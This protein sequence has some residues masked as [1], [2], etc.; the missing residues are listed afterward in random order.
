M[1]TAAIDLGRRVRGHP[2]AAMPDERQGTPAHVSGAAAQSQSPVA[3]LGFN[4]ARQDDLGALVRFHF[5]ELGYR[6][7]HEGPGEWVFERGKKSAAFLESNVRFY[8]TMLT[9]R[10]IA[11]GD[12]GQ[13][14]SCTWVVA[15]MGLAH[16]GRRDV[17][18]LESE[19]REL[20][21]LLTPSTTCGAVS[22][23]RST[24]T[25]IQADEESGA[26]TASASGRSLTDPDLDRIQMELKA[27]AVGLMIVALLHTLFWGAVG[28][29]IAYDEFLHPGQV[30]WKPELLGAIGGTVAFLLAAGTLVYGAIHLRRMTGY[31]W[32]IAACIIAMVPWSIAALIGLP[33]GIWAFRSLRRPDVR[34]AFLKRALEAHRRA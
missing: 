32:C 5:A 23:S 14:V 18:V 29:A 2:A 27:P 34:D 8:H 31:E 13:R 21:S 33:V 28:G 25:F 3:R 24:P 22:E 15:T 6:L 30:V 17:A 11:L 12:A 16:I 1:S 7:V 19:G 26:A 10:C 9:V 20:E 4:V